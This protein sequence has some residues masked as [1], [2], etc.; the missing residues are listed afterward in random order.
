MVE[1]NDWIVQTLVI[2]MI[3]SAVGIMIGTRLW[4]LFKR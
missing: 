3:V 1:S 4:I 2:V